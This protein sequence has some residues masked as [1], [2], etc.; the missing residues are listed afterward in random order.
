[1]NNSLLET[2]SE[3]ELWASYKKKRDPLIREAFIKQYAP[4]VKYVAGRVAANM[5]QS[6]EFDD[7]VGFGVFGLIDAIDKFDPEKNVKFKT[8]AVTR[9]RGAIFDELRSIDW[10]PRSVRQKSREIEDAIV[11]VES[12]LGRP[13]TDSEIANAMGVSEDDFARTMMK[14]SS[15]SILSLNDVWYSAD[16]SDKIS[17]GDS[18][19]SPVSLN[20]DAVI[21]RE[22]IKRVIV[23][24]IQELPEKEKK[25][26]V[27]YYYEDLTLKEI[28][29]VLD[30]TESRIS[31]LHTKAILRLRAK[32]TNVRKGIV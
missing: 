19:E 15:T 12:K 4:L 31:Q 2:R 22:E 24:A 9:I 1:M 8:Y 29:K 6:V 26:L 18:I 32:L 28:G 3:E 16:D 11:T 23:L 21:E 30:V 5:P 27:L 25:V 7:L 10:V 13:A 14:I 20:P 17:I